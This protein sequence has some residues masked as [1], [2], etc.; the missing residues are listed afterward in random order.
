MLDFQQKRQI[1]KVIYSR[2]TIFVLFIIVVFLGRSVYDIYTREQ[3][4]K[5]NY[6]SVKK[7]YDGLQSREAMLNS[8]IARL[9]TNNGTEE[10]IRSRF[11]VAKPGEVVV[12]VIDATSSLNTATVGDSGFWQKFK[13][14]F[15]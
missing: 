4:S 8:E 7:E 15:K 1:R 6:L 11:S 3:L 13:G 10:E 5:S 9:N 12:T 2:V 14:L